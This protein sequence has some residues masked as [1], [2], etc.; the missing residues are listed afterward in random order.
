MFFLFGYNTE[1]ISLNSKFPGSPRF[2]CHQVSP[3]FCDRDTFIRR[4][5]AIATSVS[6]VFV[7]HMPPFCRVIGSCRLLCFQRCCRI[8]QRFYAFSASATSRPSKPS[9]YPGQT[10]PPA[11]SFKGHRDSISLRY[12]LIAHIYFHQIMNGLPIVS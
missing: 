5:Y 6:A 3:Q 2:R 4:Q 8:Y 12:K 9:R 11:L 7:A 1:A 10:A